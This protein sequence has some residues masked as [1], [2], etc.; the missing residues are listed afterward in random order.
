MTKSNFKE[1]I[2]FNLSNEDYH[3]DEAISCSGVKNLLKNPKL[4][5]HNSSLNPK[6]KQL[7]TKA[8]KLGRLYHNLLLEPEKFKD[9]F[10][11]LPKGATVD[12]LSKLVSYWDY[13]KNSEDTKIDNKTLDLGKLYSTLLLKPKE[14]EKEFLVLPKGIRQNSH[15]KTMELTEEDVKHLK[16]IRD[17]EVEEAQKNLLILKSYVNRCSINE[18]EKSIRNLT[19]IR[20]YEVEEA[21]DAIN[22]IK[23]DKLYDDWFKGGYPEVSIF[24]KDQ[25][26]GLMC[27]VRF[28]YLNLNFGIDYKTTIDVQDIKKAIANY[29]YNLQSAI[30]QRGLVAMVINENIFIDGNKKQKQWVKTLKENLRKNAADFKFRFLFQEKTAPYITRPATLACDI[31][32]QSDVLFQTALNIY[33]MNYE[34]Y[35]IKKWHSGYNKIEE[36][37]ATDMPVYWS[38]KMEELTEEK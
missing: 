30:Y 35:G 34:K 4:F 24:W 5:W 31:L 23:E 27:R 14:L 33:L 10:L 28:D 8:L 22:E 25:G 19:I 18:V 1:G 38:Y 17:Y 20:D 3:A 26:T 6:K 9:E 12:F 11:V 15:L 2:Y 21:Q 29:D 7:D 16:I 13:I 36:I 37:K 32:Q